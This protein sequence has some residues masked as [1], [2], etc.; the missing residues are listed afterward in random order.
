MGYRLGH[1]L[2]RSPFAARNE[3]RTTGGRRRGGGGVPRWNERCLPRVCGRRDLGMT[4]GRI[5]VT[6]GGPPLAGFHDAPWVARRRAGAIDLSRNPGRARRCALRCL[7]REAG[8]DHCVLEQRGTAPDRV[9]AGRCDRSSVPR[10]GGE[11]EPGGDLGGVRAGLPRTLA[12]RAGNLPHA[13]DIRARGA[14]GERRLLSL[15]PMLVAGSASEP[16]LVLHLFDLSPADDGYG[17][18]WRAVREQGARAVATE[19][20]R[21]PATPPRAA[22]TDRGLQVLRRVAEGPRADCR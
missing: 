6:R 2:F 19:S 22:L 8:R 10:G 18:A 11:P 15:T 14:T 9:L 5:P 12:L 20:G 13:F 16:P 7:R 21:D 4:L 1:A 17:V 3:R